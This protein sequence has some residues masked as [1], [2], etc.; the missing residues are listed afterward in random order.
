M[1]PLLSITASTEASRAWGLMLAFAAWGSSLDGCA[2]GLDEGAGR[3]HRLP[4]SDTAA[5]TM[6]DTAHG[7]Q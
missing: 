6:P 4:V 1:D 7:G 2:L 3:E 5:H